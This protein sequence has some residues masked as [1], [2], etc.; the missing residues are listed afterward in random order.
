MVITHGTLIILHDKTIP[1]QDSIQWKQEA[2]KELLKIINK[3]KLSVH[4]V[5][6]SSIMEPQLESKTTEVNCV[7][8]LLKLCKSYRYSEPQFA[9]V[10]TSGAN[11]NPRFTFECKVSTFVA[12]GRERSKK[13]AKNSSAAKMIKIIE[14]SEN[15][16]YK[17][18]YKQMNW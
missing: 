8:A 15:F 5:E 6:L 12:T 7:G 1:S 3:C 9:L 11:H 16:L 2:A 17:K 4:L 10:E 14:V 18:K 13:G